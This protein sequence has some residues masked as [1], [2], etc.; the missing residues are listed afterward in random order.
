MLSLWYQ[1][2]TRQRVIRVMQIEKKEFLVL[3]DLMDNLGGIS[4]WKSRSAVSRSAVPRSAV[5]RITDNQR[6]EQF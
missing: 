1:C 4:T 2:Q 5:P 3:M 6:Q